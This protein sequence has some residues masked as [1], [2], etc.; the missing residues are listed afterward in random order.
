MCLW[1]LET[2]GGGEQPEEGAQGPKR[3]VLS[4]QDQK[5]DHKEH[6]LLCSE[7]YWSFAQT[8]S[9]P[10]QRTLSGNVCHVYI[11]TCFTFPGEVLGLL[12]P[13]GAGKS[14]V[15]HMLSGDTD[16]TAGQV[17]TQLAVLVS[18]VPAAGVKMAD[19]SRCR[20]TKSNCFFEQVLMGDYSTEFHHADSP[21]EHV[22]YCPQVN[23]LWPRVTLQEHLE[24]YAA[25]KGLRG[26]AVPGIISR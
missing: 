14:S 6:F 2:S 3:R 15:M 26:P 5:S 4:E 1:C 8:E 19:L 20:S 7:R 12:G 24:V 13:N 9:A 21:L 22:G 11:Y 16:P 17:Q 18:Q 25:I 23:P 10:V